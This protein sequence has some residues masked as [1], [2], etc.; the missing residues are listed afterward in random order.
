MY[1]QG[2]GYEAIASEHSPILFIPGIMGSALDDNNRWTMSDNLWPGNPHEDRMELAFKEDGKTVLV[3]GSDIKA[4]YVL[5]TAWK[6]PIYNGFYVYMDANT[7]YK[8]DGKTG[9]GDYM[10][11]A[12]FDRPYDF[13]RPT[14]FHLSGKNSIGDDVKRILKETKSDK[15]ILIAHSMGG[16]QAKMYASQNPDKVR[17]VILLSSP[18]NGAPRGFQ[19]LTEGYNFGAGLL[20]SEAHVWEIGHNWEGVFHLSPD[21]QFVKANGN[22]ISLD[23]TFGK[24]ISFQQAGHLPREAFSELQ[25]AKITNPDEVTKKLEEKYSGLSPEV[26]KNTKEFRAKFNALKADPSVRVEI[27]HGD[28]QMTTQEF[29]VRNELYTS[30]HT[31]GTGEFI[32]T[33][34]GSTELAAPFKFNIR[35]L[36]KV[37][38]AE[39]DETVHRKGFPW[40]SAVRTQT[41][42]SG[43][44]T[45]AAIPETLDKVVAIIEEVNH[46]KRDKQWIDSVKRIAGDNL[47]KLAQMSESALAEKSKEYAEAIKAEKEKKEKDENFIKKLTGDIKGRGKY[48]F[49]Q[50]M[51]EGKQNKIQIIVPEMGQYD[52]KHKDFH[53]WIALDSYTIVD[54]GVGIVQP[55]TYT[56]T[57]N[58]ETFQGVTSGTISLK[59]AWDSGNLDVSG[60]LKEN[61]L[62]WAGSWL[63]KFMSS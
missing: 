32:T 13:R 40:G 5:R 26:Y 21:H 41:V 33:E 53:A 31:Y 52:D 48:V 19:S 1:T 4:T 27:I 62:I 51:I 37:D 56:I 3:D 9:N 50:R 15:I 38:K 30:I 54:S 25:V 16:L 10:G 29:T 39:G 6:S 43:H 61:L 20:I 7:P 47:G 57:M 23:E 36:D 22:L 12:Y 49:F 35:R 44:M 58:K 11:P 45:M 34:E 59:Q 63:S 14:E 24:G 18:L 60:G 55:S 42:N 46:D 17:A 8:F 2:E 28:N